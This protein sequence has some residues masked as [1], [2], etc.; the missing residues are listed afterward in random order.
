MR[1][2]ICLVVGAGLLSLAPV[3]AQKSPEVG[4]VSYWKAKPGAGAAWAEGRKRHMD[5]HRQ[6]KDGFSWHTWE[7]INGDRA[8]G[9]LTGTFD[10]YW[11]DFDGRDAF[12]VL[13]AADMAKTFDAATESSSSGFWIQMASASRAQPG[14]TAPSKFSQLT[15]YYVRP[16]DTPRFEDALETI[17]GELD[18]I[19]WPMYSGWYR[20]ASGGDGPHYVL[21]TRRDSYAAFAPPEK[22]LMQALTEAMGARKASELFETLRGSTER[23]YTE[24]IQYRPDLS[25]VAPAK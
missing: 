25:Y 14:A 23:V 16:A 20:L 7:I 5:F 18:K 21:S 17:K 22:T 2:A 24:I 19:S 11:K 4:Q 10:H 12:D 8:G 15:H 6:Q 1:K 3:L 13:D 9:F